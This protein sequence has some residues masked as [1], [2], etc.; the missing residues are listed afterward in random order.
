MEKQVIHHSL[1]S[2]DFE[3][4]QG[5]DAQYRDLNLS[6]DSSIVLHVGACQFSAIPEARPWREDVHQVPGRT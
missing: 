1:S 6:V 5:T 4:A 2:L 3:A